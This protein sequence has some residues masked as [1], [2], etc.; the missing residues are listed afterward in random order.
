MQKGSKI[1]VKLYGKAGKRTIS[2]QDR[3]AFSTRHV[4]INLPK[5]LEKQSKIR[6]ESQTNENS[7]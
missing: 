3:N 1:K 7:I 4:K 6:K 5:L 2:V